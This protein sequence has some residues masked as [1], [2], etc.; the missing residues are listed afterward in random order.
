MVCALWFAG[1]G[2][3]HLAKIPLPP[4]LLLCPSLSPPQAVRPLPSS[5]STIDPVAT[6]QL[7]SVCA[8]VLRRVRM[9]CTLE[10]ML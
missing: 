8:T 10:V 2:D 7:G 1:S 6:L 5:R 4:L 9:Q 3:H